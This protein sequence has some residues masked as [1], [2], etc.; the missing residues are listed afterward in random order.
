[1]LEDTIPGFVSLRHKIHKQVSE[2]KLQPISSTSS[3][4]DADLQTAQPMSTAGGDMQTAP[5]PSTAETDIHT[6]ILEV[7]IPRKHKQ[8]GTQTAGSI[9]SA[10][11][12]DSHMIKLK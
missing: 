8:V 6:A 9:P 11:V 5:P 4:S 12:R 7:D 3:T 2:G 1:M 10:M